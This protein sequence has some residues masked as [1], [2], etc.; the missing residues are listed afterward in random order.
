MTFALVTFK[1]I[2]RQLIE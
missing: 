2:I 1:L